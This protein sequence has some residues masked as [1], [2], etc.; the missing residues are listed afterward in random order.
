MIIMRYTINISAE[1]ACEE[2]NCNF[3]VKGDGGGKFRTLHH[4]HET[5]EPIAI[6]CQPCNLRLG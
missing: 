1:I 6:I 2:C 4:N 3:D 5:G